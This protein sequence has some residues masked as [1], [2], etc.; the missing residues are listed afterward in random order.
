MFKIL[1]HEE[2]GICM[3]GSFQ[4]AASQVSVL[5][6]PGGTACHWLTATPDPTR[7]LFKPFI[8]CPNNTVGVS[9]RAP[10][11][12]AEDPTRVKP[13]FARTVARETPLWAAH[14]KLRTWSREGA[15]RGSTVSDHMRMMEAH[16]VDDM[17]DVV[18][19]MDDRAQARV[20]GIFEHMVELEM[21]FYK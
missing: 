14:E 20:A 16:C 10:E 21:N 8:F 5:Q 13:R 11:Y 15:A 6:A 7:S 17:D 19:N 4:S 1:R 3:T 9:T 12:G 2:S 18:K